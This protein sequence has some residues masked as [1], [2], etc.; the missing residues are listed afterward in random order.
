M[1][2]AFVATD[3]LPDGRQL[4]H[5]LWAPMFMKLCL[6]QKALCAL[7]RGVDPE[8]L[9]KWAQKLINATALMEHLVM[10][11]EWCIA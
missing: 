2:S 1:Q 4:E 6:G 10:S 7:A 3:F 11:V 8:M 5:L 9:C